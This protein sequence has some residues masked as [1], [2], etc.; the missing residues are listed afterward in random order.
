MRGAKSIT[1]GNRGRGI[2]NLRDFGGFGGE[3][4]EIST[5]RIRGEHT[6]YGG[7]RDYSEVLKKTRRR[8]TKL[9]LGDVEA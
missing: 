7:T 5:I 3:E 8:T 2:G 4:R 9:H 6:G 1:S